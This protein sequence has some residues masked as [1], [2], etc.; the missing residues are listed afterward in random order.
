MG[1]TVVPSSKT[2]AAMGMIEVSDSRN[3]LLKTEFAFAG[4]VFSSEKSVPQR[5][6]FPEIMFNTIYFYHISKSLLNTV[7]L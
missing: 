5:A 6:D 7:C 3:L 4:S 1:A 2:I